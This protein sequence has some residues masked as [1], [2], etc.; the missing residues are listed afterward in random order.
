MLTC[1]S[2]P[3]RVVGSQL[4]PSIFQPSTSVIRWYED[5]RTAFA[6]VVFWSIAAP[7]K[8]P[9]RQ[10]LGWGTGAAAGVVV[11]VVV[12]VTCSNSS[13]FV[14]SGGHGLEALGVVGVETHH[15]QQI[16]VNS[17][18]LEDAAFMFWI[19]GQDSQKDLGVVAVFYLHFSWLW[20]RRLETWECSS[21]ICT[22]ALECI[23]FEAP[24]DFIG[25][26]KV[27]GSLRPRKIISWLAWIKVSQLIFI[28]SWVFVLKSLF[29][30]LTG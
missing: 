9:R 19:C 7:G 20:I 5:S 21:P 13:R 1:A 12:V 22:S 14:W 3:S 27:I 24:D 8:L 26:T 18:M 17:S 2:L 4:P 15:K 29:W 23:K 6:Q 30:M 28:F 10:D 25:L 16:A 11:V